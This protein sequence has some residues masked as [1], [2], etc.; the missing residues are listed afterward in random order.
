MPLSG[1]TAFQAEW[2]VHF[3]ISTGSDKFRHLSFPFDSLQRRPVC[4]VIATNGDRQ[5]FCSIFGAAA[6]PLEWEPII[7][8]RRCEDTFLQVLICDVRLSC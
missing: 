7:A 6:P 3:P 2:R 5:D 4:G 1:D 8:R